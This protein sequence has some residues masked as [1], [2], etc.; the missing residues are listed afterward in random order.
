MSIIV[1][2]SKNQHWENL[3]FGSYKK[4]NKHNHPFLEMPISWIED[5]GGSPQN[6]SSKFL[7]T[8]FYIHYCICFIYINLHK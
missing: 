7:S 6:V 4:L 3:L 8:Y 5:Q 1:Y 2:G